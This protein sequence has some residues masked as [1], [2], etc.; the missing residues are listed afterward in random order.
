MFV[1]QAPIAPIK[2]SSARGFSSNYSPH[3]HHTPSPYRGVEFIHLLP[4]M[5]VLTASG[6]ELPSGSGV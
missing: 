4:M 6:G 1:V 5:A 3:H 2:P